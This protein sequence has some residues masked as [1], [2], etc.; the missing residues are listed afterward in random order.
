M[1][2]SL[3]TIKFSLFINFILSNLTAVRTNDGYGSVGSRTTVSVAR[4]PQK[5]V[6]EF[7][8]LMSCRK[9]KIVNINL[10]CLGITLAFRDWLV[11]CVQNTLRDEQR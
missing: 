7:V 6:F 3:P 2:R 5:L 10:F 9:V 4:L 11:V 8:R 1:I